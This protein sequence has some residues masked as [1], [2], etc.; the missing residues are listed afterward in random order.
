M[1]PPPM[2][3]V[4]ISATLFKVLFSKIR[5]FTSMRYKMKKVVNLAH[6]IPKFSRISLLNLCKYTLLCNFVFNILLIYLFLSIFL[7][8]VSSPIPLTFFL[9]SLSLSLSLS[10]HLNKTT[11]L[12]ITYHR[13]TTITTNHYN[14]LSI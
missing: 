8:C 4:G 2:Y 1:S 10:P 6:L 13:P 5:A 9:P 11:F 7:V 3:C 12:Q 14:T